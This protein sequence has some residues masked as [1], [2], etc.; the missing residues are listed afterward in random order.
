MS[1]IPQPNSAIV[2]KPWQTGVAPVYI[3]IFLWIAFFDQIG[4]KVL[5]MAG[6]VPAF[7]GVIVGGPLAYFCLFRSSASWGHR[8]GKSLDDLASATFGVSGAK[9]VPGLMLG[10]AQ[11]VLFA[12]AVGYAVELSFQGLILAGFVDSQAIQPSRLGGPVGRSPIF[13]ATALFWAIATALVSLRFTRWIGYLMQFFPIFPAVMLG[14]AMIFTLNGLKTF[15]PTGLNPPDLASSKEAFLLTLQWVFAF[16]ALAGVMGTDWGIGSVTLRDVRLGGWVGIGF[17]PAIVAILALI[18]VAG[19]QGSR[20]AKATPE[21]QPIQQSVISL[22]A[23]PSLPSANGL[24]APS[25]TFRALMLGA[26]P[27]RLGALILA[28]FG[29]GSLAPAVYASFAFGNRFK[30]LGP[31]LSRLT[32]TMLGTCL[33]WL[34]VVAGWMERSEAVFNVFGAIFAPVAGAFAADYRRQKGSWAGARNGVNPAGL[35]AWGVGLGVGLCPT[36]G[37]SLGSDR[38]LNVQPA[39][40]LAFVASYL[41]YEFLGLIRCESKTVPAADPQIT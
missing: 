20:E 19:Y 22:S 10:V 6:L 37:Q 4:R 24:G 38:L 29:L 3:G 31:G 8:A 23:P 36:I 35:L 16:T 41:T 32:W 14:G 11:V 26:F 30:E 2:P 39:A 18:A 9:I 27:D 13:L 7:L 21:R 40:L 5:P 34:M 1:T 28:T 12:L 15:H 33:A 25:Y 17:A